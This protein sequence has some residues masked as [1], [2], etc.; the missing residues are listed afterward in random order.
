M[1]EGGGKS[2]LVEQEIQECKE[3]VER[4]NRKRDKEKEASE[5]KRYEGARKRWV[6]NKV[7]TGLN[8]WE[9]QNG[10]KMVVGPGGRTGSRSKVMDRWSGRRK[11]ETIE[12]DRGARQRL[13]DRL[14][15]AERRIR[16]HTCIC[17]D[18]QKDIDKERVPQILSLSV[19]PHIHP[20]HYL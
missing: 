14:K 8:M 20:L 17:G 10:T 19:F 6:A 15:G 13:G 16:R 9:P 2:S 1:R 3:R 7:E 18:K 5:T 11:T 4:H 12:R